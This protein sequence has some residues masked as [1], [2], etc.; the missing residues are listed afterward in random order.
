[1]VLCNYNYNTAAVADYIWNR[2]GE[3]KDLSAIIIFSAV[4]ILSM[5]ESHC[6]QCFLGLGSSTVQKYL[7]ALCYDK[8]RIF[9]LVTDSYAGEG[10]Q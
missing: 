7:F 2:N 8:L 5:A 3:D 4:F 10:A 6:V 9:P 1:M